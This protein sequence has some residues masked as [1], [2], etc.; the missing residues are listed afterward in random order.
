MR[1]TISDVRAFSPEPLRTASSQLIEAD[2]RVEDI[3]DA[4]RRTVEREFDV[5]KG[6]A[7]TAAAAELSAT[8]RVS[9]RIS[10]AVRN[11][12]DCYA[13]AANTLGH[14]YRAV[15]MIVDD[16]TLTH[17]LTV[18][19]NGEVFPPA[20]ATPGSLADILQ[21]DHYA[22][23]AATF[24]IRLSEALDAVKQADH[25]AAE[26]LATAFGQLAELLGPP[27]AVVSD[28]IGLPGNPAALSNY[29]N[30]LSPSE[31]DALAL[32]YPAIGNRDGLPALDRDYYNRRYLESMR[33]SS[34]STYAAVAAELRP[35]MFLL[36]VSPDGHT[37]IAL[38]NPDTADNVATLVPGTGTTVAGIGGD[39]Q[40]TRAMYDAARVAS[41]GSV[42]SVILWSGYDSPPTIPGAGLD[43]YADAAAPALDAFQ[44]GLRASHD[45][46]ASHNVVIGHSYGST[47]IG[48]ATTDGRS[49]NVDDLVFV[50][51]PGV[52]AERVD[53]LRLDTTA[54][55]DMGEH[56][57]ATTA[58]WDPVQ[59]IPRALGIHGFDPADPTF[60]AQV[61]TSA[62]GS[63]GLAVHSDYWNAENPAL[64]TLGRIISGK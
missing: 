44:D 62:P 45:G 64:K 3:L 50:A 58:F 26:A 57:Y 9:G 31:K 17:G 46:P 55:A 21:G 60:G 43:R 30:T 10:I 22:E 6:E 18:T 13:G 11:V 37:A 39:L 5:W 14:A 56:V 52:D 16:A 47:V 19:D 38:G 35:D 59:L 33:E 4:A 61:F 24:G 48:A 23:A 51:S 28:P 15:N 34:A 8:L 25:T 41:P 49:L 63:P 54:G 1:P 7:A 40:R 27:V 42:N 53:E 20:P 36:S 32:R 12:A 29:W 2:R